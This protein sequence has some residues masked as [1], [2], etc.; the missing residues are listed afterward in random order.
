MLGTHSDT[1]WKDMYVES[2][3]SLILQRVNER[4]TSTRVQFEVKK[5]AGHVRPCSETV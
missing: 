3:A 4:G 1:S 5:A 2:L